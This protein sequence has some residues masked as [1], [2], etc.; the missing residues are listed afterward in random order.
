M[1]QLGEKVSF[2]ATYKSDLLEKNGWRLST[3]FTK[4]D[5]TY[6]P[7]QHKETDVGKELKFT[8]KGKFAPS[9]PERFWN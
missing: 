3:F 2:V 5:P 6:F 7:S 9:Y 4:Y 8:A 1:V